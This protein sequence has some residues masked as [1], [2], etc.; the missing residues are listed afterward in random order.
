MSL[1]DEN[2]PWFGNPG[3]GGALSI[4]LGGMTGKLFF[5]V[6]CPGQHPHERA[7][8]IVKNGHDTSVKGHPQQYYCE[9]CGASFYTHTSAFF[10]ALF[11]DL[12]RLLKRALKGGRLDLKEL[13]A[14][15]DLSS[16]AASRLLA[17]LLR[18]LDAMGELK[19]YKELPR[20]GK[21]LFADETFLK[22]QG[23]QWYIVVF[24]NEHGKVLDA[25][26]TRQRSADVLLPRVRKVMG[27]MKRGVS[28]IVTDDFPAYQGVVLALRTD[29][30]HVRCVHKPPY[31]RVIIDIVRWEGNIAHYTTAAT[32][33]DV[34]KARNTFLARVTKHNKKI[35][36]PGA[37]RGHPKGTK[38]RP[39]AVTAAERA[40]KAAQHDP[41]A[42]KSGRK[43]YTRS[44]AVHVFHY[45]PKGGTVEPWGGSDCSVAQMFTQLLAVFAHKCITT[46]LE[47]RFFSLLKRLIHFCGWRTPEHWQQVIDLFVVLR[48]EKGAVTHLVDMLE[49]RPQLLLKNLYNLTTFRVSNLHPER[50]R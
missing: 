21:V 30:L 44:G 11:G 20:D 32:I 2:P 24:Q 26:V 27:R 36:T 29:I 12:K 42:R 34:L 22:I 5:K 37:K 38:N 6:Q 40:E 33:S 19:R 49:F 23:E 15:F 1:A 17:A 50:K 39:L 9:T 46:N 28:I 10:R 13:A 8:H 43:N 45:N 18:H 14:R 47:E 7:H 3:D 41:D 4:G 48:Q 25:F 16:S 35:K 31:G